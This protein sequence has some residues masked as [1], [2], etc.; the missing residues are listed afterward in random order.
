VPG[1]GAGPLDRVRSS[2]FEQNIDGVYVHLSSDFVVAESA[3]TLTYGAEIFETSSIS[4]RNGSTS[5]AEG[6]AQ[7]ERTSFPTRDFPIT[8]V[9]QTAL[10]VQNESVSF[11]DRLRVTLG[12][13]FDDFEAKALG[14]PVYY[15]GNPGSPVPANFEDSE[16][17][18]SASVVY[19]LHQNLSSYFRY[20]EGFRAPPYDDVNVGFT[21]PI[22]G[23]KT[24]SN[25]NLKS[26]TS[27]GLEIGIRWGSESVSANFSVYQNDY[28]NFIES[29]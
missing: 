17:T 9:R 22:G 10:F 6:V 12:A 23:Y 5:N 25:P 20:S 13:R 29:L 14:D 11:N 19:R 2:E 24:I 26:E 3:N 15:S 16:T 21:N 18:L 28:E 8:D 4:I 7:I 1:L 27:E